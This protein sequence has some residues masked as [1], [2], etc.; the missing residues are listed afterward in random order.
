MTTFLLPAAHLAGHR[1]PLPG[2][3]PLPKLVDLSGGV[4]RCDERHRL[5]RS[6][7]TYR[8]G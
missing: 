4:A 2:D 6:D 1:C 8:D 3:R 5:E 7:W